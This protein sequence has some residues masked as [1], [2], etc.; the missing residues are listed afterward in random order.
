MTSRRC[1]VSSAAQPPAA[2]PAQ[3]VHAE[4]Q[5]L[6]VR[7]AAQCGRNRAA[8][9]VIGERQP[10]ECLK[11]PQLG[12][13]RDRRRCQGCR[14]YR[15]CLAPTPA[16]HGTRPIGRWPFPQSRRA[17]RTR[18]R[19]DR[20]SR[21]RLPPLAAL[22]FELG[23][24][25][26]SR[27]RDCPTSRSVRRP[28]RS[29]L[30]S[31]Y[32]PSIRRMAMAA[33][34]TAARITPVCASTAP[35]NRHVRRA[36]SSARSA[37]SC[38]HPRDRRRAPPPTGPGSAAHHHTEP[39]ATAPPATPCATD[40]RRRSAGRRPPFAQCP[41]P[42]RASFGA[43]PTTK[44]MGASRHW[45]ANPTILRLLGPT[46]PSPAGV[47]SARVGA[48]QTRAPSN[49]QPPPRRSRC[50][51][52][53]YANLGARSFVLD[54]RF[55]VLLA[56]FSECPLGL[57]KQLAC[58]DDTV[59]LRCWCCQICRLLRTEAV[60]DHGRRPLSGSDGVSDS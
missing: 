38:R 30:F 14:R 41:F 52:R 43:R 59:P 4:V 47:E 49:P 29:R 58:L 40:R 2:A 53:G 31:P 23:P 55:L 9:R 32:D 54:P 24:V 44:P 10:S 26:V 57:E 28:C 19:P 48:E 18:P 1:S 60:G 37:R 36:S 56:C 46:T 42:P 21:A 20:P 6:E 45:P 5:L 8:Q 11:A 34:I 13:D 33:P 15:S 35:A 12:R 50:V 3:L 17:T 51:V 7:Q 27:C 25:Q 22:A 16:R 39:A